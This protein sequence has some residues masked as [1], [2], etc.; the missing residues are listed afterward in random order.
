MKFI[1]VTALSD[2]SVATDD[3]QSIGN[4]E[5]L[6]VET[7][8]ADYGTF[9][10]NQFVLDG[11]K[12]VMPDLP[13]DIVF[14]SVEQSGEDCL[15]QKNP[16]LTIT[17]SAQ[18]SS[19]GITLYFADE[20]PAELTIT[21]YT[22]SGS[23]LDQKTFYPDNLV[24]ACVHQVANYGKVVIEFVR[25]RLPKRYIKLRY[26]LYGRYIEWTGDVIKTAKIHEEI[27]EISTTLS[28]NTA[29]ISILDAKN[30]FDISNEN[31]SWRSVQKTQEV[32]FTENKDGVDISVGTFSLIRRILK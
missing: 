3:N 28:I 4:L 1:D 11:N 16:R 29:S 19:A 30:D 18:H 12:N 24:Y 10:L 32:T 6:E 20:Y 26:I 22:L 9:E 8:Q 7:D 23:K 15:F 21:W 27:N 2:A 13:G 17:F 25:T 5:S 14:W 31:G